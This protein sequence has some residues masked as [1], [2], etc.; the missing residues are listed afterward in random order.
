MAG[1]TVGGIPQPVSGK[2][3]VSGRHFDSRPKGFRCS[4]VVAADKT[5]GMTE[6]F[7]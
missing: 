5:L 1:L 6:S 7:T 2:I 3:K 4:R